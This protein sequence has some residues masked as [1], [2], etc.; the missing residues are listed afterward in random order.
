MSM[1]HGA[2]VSLVALWTGV[3][4][5]SL[6]ACNSSDSS[7][8]PDAGG[9][10]SMSSTGGDG[11]GVA[12]SS[13][14]AGGT[15]STGPSGDA[16]MPG[17]AGTDGEGGAPGG[18]SANALPDSTFLYVYSETPDSDLLVAWDYKT[19]E[20]RVITDLRDDDS[21][22]WEIW[23]HSISPDRRRIALA[24]LY[25][26][27]KA[28]NDTQLATRRVWTFATDGT[29]AQRLTPVFPNDGQGRTGFN[30]SVQDPVFTG[31]GRAVI[32]DFG[33]WWY[34]GTTLEGGSLPWLVSTSGDLPELFPT[35]TSCSV[36]D[37]SVN[38]ATGD[39]LFVHSV[40]VNAEDEGIF[41]YPSAGGSEPLKLVDRGYGPGTVDPSLEKASWLADGSG[42][43]FVGNI[44]ITRGAETDTASSLLAYD[45]NS[46]EVGVL[47][48]PE[49]DTSVRN[50]AVAPDGAGI[51]Y[52]LAQDDVY[53]LHVVDLTVDPP[54]DVAITNDGKSCSPGF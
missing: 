1:K 38:P 21:D 3:A 25:G 34:E 45:M 46:G 43:V 53:D 12:G 15:D 20:Q 22:G 5:A 39:V 27:T 10:D 54:E 41:L 6:G 18:A 24:A 7:A 51:V 17:T 50:A 16:G 28:D 40:C 37:P 35:V 19:G 29:D 47:V 52:C 32:Y 2:L 9:S 44:E 31:D 48:I 36:I 42:F 30:L 13:D 33:T 4:A 26:P 8:D 23:G 14:S 49:P 11:D